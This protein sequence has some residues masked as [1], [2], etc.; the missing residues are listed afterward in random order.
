MNTRLTGSL[1][2]NNV[3]HKAQIGFVENHRTSDH[4]FTLK[5]V[6]AKHVN[7]T[8][9]GR[10]YGCFVDF[11]KA[12]DS[13][14]HKGL[15]TKL[16]NL[17]VNSVFINII[18][19]MYSKSLCA[20][21]VINSRTEFFRCKRG[22]RQGCSLSPILFKI[23][24]DDLLTEVDRDKTHSVQLGDKQCITCLAYADDI[25]ILSKSAIGLQRS[26]DILDRFC[27]TWNMKV[28]I[29]KIKCITFQKKNKVN[30]ND[31]FHIGGYFVSNICEF[32]YLGLTINAAGSFKSSIEYLSQ[33][34][35]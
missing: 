27:N 9:R 19:D 14:W 13:V 35:R 2:K 21:K 29:K 1:N 11:K 16:E 10:I 17:N 25:L 22:V 7:T 12:Y 20:V 15:F 23:Y 31:I 26:L 33:K 34:A 18:K 3:V 28:N 4:V 6:I 8:S 32:T 5:S 30:K 24:L